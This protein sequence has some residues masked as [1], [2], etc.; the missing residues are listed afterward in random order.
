[1]VRVIHPSIV[2]CEKIK[3]GKK[4]PFK[5]FTNKNYGI[6]NTLSDT[7]RAWIFLKDYLLPLKK[8]NVS[9]K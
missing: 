9:R 4:S 5:I 6:K 8:R 2:S 7:C 3:K 1:M